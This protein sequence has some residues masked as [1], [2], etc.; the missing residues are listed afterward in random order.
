MP[1]SKAVIQKKA[2]LRRTTG[3]LA[4]YIKEVNV[5]RGTIIA[6][7]CFSIFTLHT[8]LQCELEEAV[9]DHKTKSLPIKSVNSNTRAAALESKL[10]KRFTSIN[11]EQSILC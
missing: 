6:I 1:S 4:F 7:N 5:I 3:Y 9:L 2:D 10:M 8:H 11:S